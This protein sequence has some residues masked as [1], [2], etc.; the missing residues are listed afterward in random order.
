MTIR[1]CVYEILLMI[2]VV[3]NFIWKN[4]SYVT[5]YELRDKMIF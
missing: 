1:R 5:S 2:P 4:E 3:I